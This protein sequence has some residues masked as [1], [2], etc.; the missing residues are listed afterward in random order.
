LIRRGAERL[1]CIR[2]KGNWADGALIIYALECGEYRKVRGE[3]KEKGRKKGGLSILFYRRRRTAVVSGDGLTG[4]ESA[5]SKDWR[6]QTV[7]EN[8]QAEST[9][10]A[11]FRGSSACGM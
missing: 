2:K 3:K 10:R 9:K 11:C 1:P 4:E 8:T 5:D 7:G 6:I